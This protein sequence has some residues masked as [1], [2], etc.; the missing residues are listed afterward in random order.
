MSAQRVITHVVESEPLFVTLS[1]QQAWYTSAFVGGGIVWQHESVTEKYG[2]A[3]VESLQ[4]AHKIILDVAGASA[5]E[6]EMLIELLR[7]HQDKLKLILPIYSFWELAIAGEVPNWQQAATAQKSHLL[8]WTSILPDAAIIFI[9]DPIDWPSPSPLSLLLTQHWSGSLVLLPSGKVSLVSK[10]EIVPLLM[11]EMGSPSRGSVLVEATNYALPSLFERAVPL[12]ESMHQ[13]RIHRQMVATTKLELLP[14]PCRVRDVIVSPEKAIGLAVELLPTPS[15][16]S[17]ANTARATYF[18]ALKN[19]QWTPVLEEIPVVATVVVAQSVVAAPSVVQLESPPPV[20]ELQQEPEP[21]TSSP[22]PVKAPIEHLE[23][24]ATVVVSEQEKEQQLKEDVQKLFSTQTVTQHKKTIV[25]K[26]RQRRVVK[27]RSKKR[28]LIFYLGLTFVGIGL[29]FAALLGSLQ[30]T[31]Q[32]IRQE[33]T[34][35]AS[36]IAK[37]TTPGTQTVR[38]GKL[39]LLFTILSPQQQIASLVFSLPLIDVGDAMVASNSH[40][41]ELLSLQVTIDEHAIALY[42]SVMGNNTASVAQI[43]EEIKTTLQKENEAAEALE[44]IA[45]QL[46]ESLQTSIASASA[47]VLPLTE[48]R[49]N[50]V[51]TKTLVPRLLSLLGVDGTR[52]YAVV[53]QN[54]QELRPT[55]GFIE[56][57]AILT[58]NE[59]SIT[60]QDVYSSYQLDTKIPGAI[61]PPTDLKATIGEEQWWLHDANWFADSVQSAKQISWFLEKTLQEK[62]DGVI[63]IN[64]AGLPQLLRSLGPLPMQV[65]NEVLTEKNIDERLEFHNELPSQITADKPEYRQELLSQ[66]LTKLRTLSPEQVPTLLRVLGELI[67]EKQ[68]LFFMENSDDHLAFRQLGWTGELAFPTCP[69]EYVET[70]CVSDGIAIVESNIGANRANAHIERDSSHTA[71]LSPTGARHTRSV[72]YTNAATTRAWPK[73]DYRAYIRTYVPGK[74]SSIAA[75]LSGVPIDPTQIVVRDA[76]VGTEIGFIITVPVASTAELVLTYEQLTPLPPTSTYVFYETRQPGLTEDIPSLELTYPEGWDVVSHK[77]SATQGDSALLFPP[78]P[79]AYLMR[80]IQFTPAQ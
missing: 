46:P 79:S 75:S 24:P 44:E 51:L 67:D 29:L 71:V 43:L 73:G 23:V 48:R 14:F 11:E 25:E 66:L 40:L 50:E 33:F 37:T 56:A 15:Q 70:G 3:L 68:V 31:Q 4:E 47:N 2:A 5:S 38:W 18:K 32:L 34:A 74:P 72:R 42:D 57:V 8:R 58:F 62:P 52:R 59:G 17:D 45:M 36:E 16:V 21:P 13:A 9:R 53:L 60:S 55:G 39:P 20:V 1:H 28:T 63:V 6:R 61:E 19:D 78:T 49:R 26:S 41:Q 54:S 69:A 7:P 10:Q 64:T 30:I 12:Y 80:A 35:V 27:K 65:F 76:G 77:P 22:T